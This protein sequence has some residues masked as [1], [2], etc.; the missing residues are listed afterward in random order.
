MAIKRA[1]QIVIFRFPQTDLVVGKTRPALLLAS[2]PSGYNNW[3]VCMISTQTRQAISGID[4]AISISDSD[5][6]Q[7]GLKTD[8]IIRLT[9]LAVVSD[10]IFLGT[11]GEISAERLENLKNK[12]ANWIKTS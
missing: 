8:S 2:L 5:F 3:L 9:R 11:T 6:S 1:G 10:S 4:E 12:L 7:S